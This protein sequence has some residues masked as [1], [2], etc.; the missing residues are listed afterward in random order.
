MSN[1]ANVSRLPVV[2]G[3]IMR[4]VADIQGNYP[5][6]SLY[7]WPYGANR[8]IVWFYAEC[9][10]CLNDSLWVSCDRYIMSRNERRV[11][12]ICGCCLT[13]TYHR[14]FVISNY[15]YILRL[16][17][18]DIRLVSPWSWEFGVLSLVR[19]SQAWGCMWMLADLSCLFSATHHPHRFL[20]LD[21][22]FFLSLFGG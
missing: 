10:S 6:V 22:R 21:L 4:Y 5:H 9:V 7:H 12:C 2:V 18:W 19:M 11:V 8:T 1:R 17:A 13:N 14:V 15:V 20:L 3:V 16:L